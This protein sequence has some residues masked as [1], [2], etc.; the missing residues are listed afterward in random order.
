MAKWIKT[1]AKKKKGG[2]LVV[3][4][5]ILAIVLLFYSVKGLIFLGSLIG[6]DKIDMSDTTYLRLTE[7]VVLK[8]AN[9]R[10]FISVYKYGGT[11]FYQVP[12][13]VNYNYKCEDGTKGTVE[14]VGVPTTITIMGIATEVNYKEYEIC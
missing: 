10:E 7:N 4:A 6:Q 11:Y 14:A 2:L 8:D 5:V 3:I 12:T 1:L 13:G 9:F